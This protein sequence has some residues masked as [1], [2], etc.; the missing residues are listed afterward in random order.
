MLSRGESEFVLDLIRVGS[1][2][3]LRYHLRLFDHKKY[4]QLRFSYGIH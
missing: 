2:L 1:Q 4:F 3:S